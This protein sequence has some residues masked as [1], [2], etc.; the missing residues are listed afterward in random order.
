M[1]LSYDCTVQEN[2]RDA[3]FYRHVIVFTPFAATALGLASICLLTLY[4]NCKK[5]LQVDPTRANIHISEWRYFLATAA[6]L[7]P[8]KTSIRS[9]GTGAGVELELIFIAAVITASYNIIILTNC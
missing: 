4:H 9:L 2:L 6:Y 7:I 5:K 1:T 8:W 3:A